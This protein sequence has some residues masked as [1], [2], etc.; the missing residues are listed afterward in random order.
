MVDINPQTSNTGQPLRQPVMPSAP[1]PVVPVSEPADQTPK[2]ASVNPTLPS[3]PAPLVGGGQAVSPV[4]PPKKPI[5][6]VFVVLGI[7]IVAVI[8]GG[9]YYLYSTNSLPF[10][11]NPPP[12]PTA[13]PSPA[14]IKFE[15][16]TASGELSTDDS[17]ERIE[18]ELNETTIDDFSEDFGELEKD[19][20]EL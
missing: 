9:G 7:L 17:E 15:E 2:P 13:L 20:G 18:I 11:N 1:K 10:F 12:P 19:A 8:V 16:A 14:P 6:V 5:S 4:S 3:V